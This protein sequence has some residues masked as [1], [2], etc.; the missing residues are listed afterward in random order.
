MSLPRTG[1]VNG[2]I[3]RAGPDMHEQYCNS[4]RRRLNNIDFDRRFMELTRSARA[5]NISF[6]PIGVWN[7][8]PVL[9]VEML[10]RG[11][12]PPLQPPA[13]LVDSL[14]SLAKD[15]GG[16]LVPPMGDVSSGLS[17][18]AGDVGTH[19]LLGYYTTNTKWDG[20]LRSIR[21]Q[22]KRT[23]AEIRARKD[24]RAPTAEDIATLSAPRKPGERIVAAPVAT[25]LSVLSAA[26]PSAQ[27]FAYGA[28][29]GKILYVTLE[30]P[31]IAVE[32]GRWKDGA[33]VDV[34]AEAADGTSVGLAHGRLG[35]NGRASL[36][37]PLDGSAAPASVFVRVR[38]EGESI[39][40]RTQVGADRG[41]LV[42]D[43]LAFRSSGRGLAI[44]VASFVFARDE[45]LRLEWPVLGAVDRF[46][47]RF[48]DRYGLPLKFRV[49]VDDQPVLGARRL[50]ATLS[51]SS[52]GRGDYVIELAASAGAQTERH[53]L[54]V[55]V[56]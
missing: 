13:A 19:Y 50:V 21:V 52:L 47:A 11:V 35:A 20:K 49:A 10:A 6:Y 8:N 33:S 9:P 32:A 45:R 1:L 4:E 25:A 46:E 7:P 34:I 37:V 24:Y 39:T 2:R 22:L 31:A 43:A 53:Y 23:G 41:V 5:A 51:L 40:Q 48:L 44:P 27:F 42:G 12:R 3:Q 16:F 15:T 55:R 36:Q 29:A 26:R 14:V 18:I 38:A 54:A 56:N 17:R 28:M 30:T